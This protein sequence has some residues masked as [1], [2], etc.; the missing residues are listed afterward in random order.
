MK[1]STKIIV[2]LTLAAALTIVPLVGCTGG[3]SDGNTSEGDTTAETPAAV[4]T[5][6]WTTL[7]DVFANTDER[8]SSGSSDEIYIGVFKSGESYVR[9]VAEFTPEV[10]AQTEELDFFAEDYDEQYDAIVG[11]LSL[12]SAEDITADR[13][14][15]SDYASYVGKTGQN[16]ID[17]GFTFVYYDGYGGDETYALFD[18]GYFS[19]NVTFDVSVS[20]DEEDGA[21]VMGATI[22]EMQC[23]SASDAATDPYAVE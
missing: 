6:S 16:L 22:T 9:V 17:E 3:T 15:E 1:L 7:A 8:L 5:S 11:A 19:Y 2:A 23:I 20:E 12:K 18:K 21:S 13:I 4:D 10:Y 14:A